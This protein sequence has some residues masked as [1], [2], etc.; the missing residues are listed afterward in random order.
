VSS[1]VQFTG[2]LIGTTYKHAS[3]SEPHEQMW[4][5]VSIVAVVRVVS[6]T[7][8][9]LLSSRL[10]RLIPVPI[11]KMVQAAER[12]SIRIDDSIRVIKSANDELSFRYDPSNAMLNERQPTRQDLATVHQEL[13][14]FAP[15]APS[16]TPCRPF[17]R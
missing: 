12:I 13:L 10:Q 2:R 15:R 16:E 7:G 3:M 8:S 9:L 14:V 11:L 6:S 4:R 1:A 5:Y 17:D